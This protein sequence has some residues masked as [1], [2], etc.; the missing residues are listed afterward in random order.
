[1]GTVLRARVLAQDRDQGLRALET[2]FG[3]IGDVEEL[4]S[5]W[6]GSSELS[7]LNHYPVGAKFRTTARLFRVL[8]EALA[9]TRGTGGSFDPGVGALVD[10]WDLRGEG[11]VPS[12]AAVALALQSVGLERF[13][14]SPSDSTATRPSPAAWID[15]G[16]FGKGLALRE[17]EKALRQAG[18]SRAELDFGG[19]VLVWSAAPSEVAP[20]RIGVAHPRLRSKPVAWLG[21]ERGSVATS[22]GSERSFVVGG[23]RVSHVLDPRSGKPVPNWGSVTVV[24]RD[25]VEADVLSTALFVMGPDEGMKWLAERGT[26][27]A[28]FIEDKG[29]SLRYRHSAALEPFLEAVR[30]GRNQ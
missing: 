15:A 12:P 28:L 23:R 30:Q 24:S 18:V 2:A 16:A 1:M 5:S 10:A 25:P 22:S 21:I 29:D 11:R 4:L 14:L 6:S 8:E 27:A 9:W 20:H 26:V 7:R 3:R 19:Q 13:S 17:A